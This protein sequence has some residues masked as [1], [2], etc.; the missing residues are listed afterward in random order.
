MMLEFLT[1]L[2]FLIPAM[3]FFFFLGLLIEASR[4][5]EPG[6]ALLVAALA[7]AY[8]LVRFLSKVSD[9]VGG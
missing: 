6:W 7:C 5:G 4:D 1:F 2:S 3:G 8:F 9:L